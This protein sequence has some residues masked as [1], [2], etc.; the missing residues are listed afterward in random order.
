MIG[1]TD[2]V[3]IG[4][5]GGLALGILIA[6]LLFF[7]IRWYK[8]RAHLCVRANEHN[9]S[10]PTLPIRTNGLGTST[11]FSASLTNSRAIQG[12]E[13]L[14]KIPHRSW[15]KHQNKDRFVST[16]GILRY[17]YK[18]MVWVN[19]IRF[20]H[21]PFVERMK[22][23]G[24][25]PCVAACSSDLW[26]F[27]RKGPWFNFYAVERFLLLGCMKQV[28]VLGR[29]HHRN[30][31]NLV[32]YCVDKGQY[33]LVYE[34]MSNGSLENLLHGQEEQILSWDERL[35][36]AL[37]ISHG[38]EYLHE[39]AVPPVIHRDLKSANILLDQ[40]MRAKVAD[41]GLSKEEVFDGR[42]SGLKGTY[43]Y[44][45]PAYISTNKFTMKSDVYSFG[46]IIFELITAIHPQQNL[47]DYVDLA[48]MTPNGVD[49]ILDKKLVGECSL[50]EVRGLASIGHKCLNQLPR[51]RPS[52]G[53]VSQAI[54]KIRQRRLAKVDTMSFAGRDFSLVSRIENQQLELSRM[55]SQVEIVSE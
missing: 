5:L 29:L 1:R 2:L 24:Y 26:V 53:E 8:K 19:H 51:K 34:F 40:S 32:G 16:S 47:M 39:G 14:Q 48:A 49:E 15:W 13:K 17:S 23:T 22:C 30:L 54:L 18:V 55:T 41:F 28:S 9:V 50:E 37:D 35:Q 21:T 33:M 25:H 44:I 43:G 45:D 36:I 20:L 38:I 46:I 6:S 7:G 11:D 10:S 31:V 52:I 4:V 12:S 27:Q 3:I 42:N